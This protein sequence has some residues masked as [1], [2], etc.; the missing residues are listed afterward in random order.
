MKEFLKK[1][2][3]VDHLS[4]EIEIDQRQFVERLKEHVDHGNIGGFSTM[5]EAFSS[6]K[7]EYKGLVNFDGFK[8]KRKRR[9]FDANMG[10]A[11]ATGNFQQKNQNLI[12][13]TEINGFSGLMIPFYIVI[14]IFYLIF[15]AVL[16]LASFSEEADSTFAFAIPFI[17]L[18]ASFMFGIP[19]LMMRRSTTRMKHEL[20]REFFYMTKNKTT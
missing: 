16:T 6:G 17:L 11:V 3:L 18:H 8:I 12:I 2:K 4:T 1:L 9:L 5:F 20:E 15:I 14:T 7:N 13:S 10:M 19:Y